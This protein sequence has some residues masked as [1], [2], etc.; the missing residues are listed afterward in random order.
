[1]PGRA[2]AWLLPVVLVALVAG[3][4][5][6]AIT[7]PRYAL[8]WLGTAVERRDAE[9]ALAF[10]DVDAI[11]DHAT[12]VLAADYLARQ[13][14]PA[15]TAEASGRELL[16]TLARRRLRP[17]VAA[18]IRAE[19]ERSMG[20]AGGARPIGLPVGALA[21]VTAVTVTRDGEGSW[22]AYQDP[23][24][25]PV[26]FR[27]ARNAGGPWKITEFDPEW[28]RRKAREEGIRLH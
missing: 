6:Y 5:L 17:L 1:M 7:T 12:A 19:I 21:V 22:V 13:P 16:V 9:A 24:Q 15:S 14:A 18:R 11:A 8:Y 25:G 26:R 4:A 27:M 28:V 3:A 10:F 23:D 20:R 2:W